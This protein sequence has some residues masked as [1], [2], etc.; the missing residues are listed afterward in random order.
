[1]SFL[2][3]EGD[4]IDP[5]GVSGVSDFGLELIGVDPVDVGLVED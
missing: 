1:M 3:W 2:P 5:V 4:V